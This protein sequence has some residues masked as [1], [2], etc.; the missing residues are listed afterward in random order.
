MARIL[1][2]GSDTFSTLV[3]DQL[4]RLNPALAIHS[5][6]PG[7][8]KTGRSLRNIHTPALQAFV[9][10]NN[11]P[12][13]TLPRTTDPLKDYRIPDEFNTPSDEDPI[14][15][16]ASFPY[17]IPGS[18]SRLFKPLKAINVH[19]SI[20]PL[21]RGAAPI[22]WQLAH[23]HRPLGVSI[24]A[25]NHSSLAS[26]FDTGKILVQKT[27]DHFPLGSDYEK[28]EIKLANLSAE[29]LTELIP[30]INTY[31]VE[32]KANDQDH[33][34]ATYAPKISAQDLLIQPTWTYAEI[35]G[36]YL[37]M[38][39]HYPPSISI[40]SEIYQ[41]T[42]DKITS[43]II[44]RPINLTNHNRTRTLHEGQITPGEL[45]YEKKL[46]R[47]LLVTGDKRV[48]LIRAAKVMKPGGK[49]WLT[50]DPW[51][52]RLFNISKNPYKSLK[53]FR[54]FIDDTTTTT[55]TS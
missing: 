51:W 6:I 40:N 9:E 10:K 19:P 35:M 50:V 53:T 2:F 14:L 48:V 17:W 16:S 52:D 43:T 13:L 20:L 26:S 42:I 37:G 12:H 4:I 18:I 54:V 7:G 29:M 49:G 30:N 15:I 3:L 11:I 1:F 39:H 5:V 41:L 45:L 47:V 27:L 24:Q 34:K 25:L 36:R 23:Y 38:N 31:I 22:Q 33:S 55:T 8:V 28:A 46:K 21:Y 44:D 32:D